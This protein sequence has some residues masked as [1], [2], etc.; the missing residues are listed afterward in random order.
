MQKVNSATIT[1]Q[2]VLTAEGQCKPWFLK[3]QTAIYG[4]P[5][6]KNGLKPG[7]IPALF[8]RDSK[9]W[10]S[11]Q[12]LE[13]YNQSSKPVP[14]SFVATQNHLTA[15]IISMSIK[16]LLITSSCLEPGE[17]GLV[18]YVLDGRG[19]GVQF[20]VGAKFVSSPRWPYRFGSSSG[21]L[22]NEYR[23]L[24]PLGKM[25]GEWSWPRTFI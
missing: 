1:A 23:Q 3:V 18:W 17:S 7:S 25:D 5:S 22:S 9:S 24:F 20:P 4:S 13:K 16:L 2:T 21:F 8:W 14:N 19:V 6:L 11:T 15:H 10:R 12:V